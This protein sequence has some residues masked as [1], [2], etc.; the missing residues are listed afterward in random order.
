[1]KIFDRLYGP[2]TFTNDDWLLFQTPEMARLRELSLSA[3]PPWLNPTGVCASKFEHTLGVAY[4]AREMLESFQLQDAQMARDLYF[5]ALAHDLGTPPFSHISEHFQKLILGKNHEEFAAEI[6]QDSHFGQEIVKQGGD[7]ERIVKLINGKFFPWSELI[8]GSIDID[9]IDN[10]LRYGWSMGLLNTKMYSPQIL[11]RN[12][13]LTRDGLSILIGAVKHYLAWQNCR[14]KIYQYVHSPTNLSRGMMIF[15]AL[16]LAS[17]SQDLGRDYFLLTDS[18]A[19]SYLERKCN[20]H[21]KTIITRAKHWQFYKLVFS[22]STTRPGKSLIQAAQDPATRSGMSDTLSKLIGAPDEDV[23]FYIGK[24]RGFKSLK[25]PIID[26]QGN[27]FES[28]ESILV[29]TWHIQVFVDLKWVNQRTKNKV[30][31]CVNQLFIC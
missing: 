22:F 7:L 9:N 26:P 29:P 17:R 11:A 5:A 31:D 1:M 2:L 25:I 23:C 13:H 6:I 3:V 14:L 21:T 10:S 18:E 16:D 28:P 27:H 4:L 8:N 30:K 12:F 19:F 15:R 20:T 24:D